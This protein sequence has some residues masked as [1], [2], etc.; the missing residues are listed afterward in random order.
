MAS[1]LTLLTALYTTLKPLQHFFLQGFTS[2]GKL[3]SGIDSHDL[4][5]PCLCE[6][7]EIDSCHPSRTILFCF[8]L[9]NKK[10]TVQLYLPLSCKVASPRPV[11]HLEHDPNRRK[12]AAPAA[13]GAMKGQVDWDTPN[14]PG[15]I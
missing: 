1:T 5:K 11:C 10:A 15:V 13:P 8:P 2:V 14:G 4:F 7:A 6:V 3:L 9:S 12:P